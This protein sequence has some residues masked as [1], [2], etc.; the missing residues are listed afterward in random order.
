M[1]RLSIVLTLATGA[2]LTGAL[3]ILFLSLD[4]YGWRPIGLAALIGFGG[5]WPAALAISRRI[6]RRDRQWDETRIRSADAVPRPGDP[7]V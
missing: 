2:V 3:V 7:E 6:K 4:L 1:D 5:A